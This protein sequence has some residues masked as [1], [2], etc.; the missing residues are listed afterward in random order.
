MKSP[1][2]HCLQDEIRISQWTGVSSSVT[3]LHVL[4]NAASLKGAT[5]GRAPLAR[6]LCVFMLQ[7]HFLCRTH[8]CSSSSSRMPHAVTRAEVVCRPLSSLSI[9][10]FFPLTRTD[11]SF[12]YFFCAYAH[13]FTRLKVFNGRHHFFFG[14]PSPRYLYMPCSINVL[15]KGINGNVAKNEGNWSLSIKLKR[16]QL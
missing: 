7:P 16:A 6:V 1:S 2:Y 13:L 10:V 9:T 11:H 8:S 15:S 5:A 3:S 14:T 12:P 4:Y